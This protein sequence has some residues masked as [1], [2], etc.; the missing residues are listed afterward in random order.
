VDAGPHARLQVFAERGA[1]F[2]NL[3]DRGADS[4]G[5]RDPPSIELGSGP[6]RTPAETNRGAQLL[7]QGLEL[8]A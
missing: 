7:L 6:P 5:D 4:L 3:C 2:G 8:R 1:R